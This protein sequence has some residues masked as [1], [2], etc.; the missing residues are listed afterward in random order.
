M[1]H[2][3]DST[4]GKDPP[5][6]PRS[7]FLHLERTAQ[8]F[9]RHAQSKA[10]DLFYDAM[11]AETDDEEFELLAAALE[12]D[13][14][15]VDA[16]LAMLEHL[17]ALPPNEE[18]ETM[19]KLVTIAEERLGK[20]VFKE[21]AGAFWGYVETRPYM[22]ARACLANA[23]HS[24]G[25]GVEA[26]EEWEEMLKLNPND[27]QGV[28]YRLL[29]THL[30]LGRMDDARSLLNRYDEAEFNTIFAW[31]NVL[32]R[33]ASGE[34]EGAAEAA[35]AAIKQNPSSKAYLLGHRRIPKSTPPSYSPGSK[36][37]A[38]CFAEDLQASWSAYPAARKWLESLKPKNR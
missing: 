35:K 15:N 24:A 31:A 33:F 36:E 22:R 23:L 13:P 5:F 30:Q 8:P 37:E 6:D 18:I 11:E 26:V 20:K 2:P 9:S 25:K 10:Q 34:L 32:E 28:R 4:E 19:R 16:L 17:P 14:Q 21:M 1:I 3:E 29:A 38:V 12:L 27:N 7:L